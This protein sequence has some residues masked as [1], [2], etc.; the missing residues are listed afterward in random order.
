[1]RGY[2][3]TAIR[4]LF[5]IQGAPGKKPRPENLQRS[6]VQRSERLAS[7]GIMGAQLKTSLKP[8]N[9]HVEHYGIEGFKRCPQLAGELAQATGGIKKNQIIRCKF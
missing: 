3:V 2:K 7:L 4:M 6:I 9:H 5:V 8:L 1:M